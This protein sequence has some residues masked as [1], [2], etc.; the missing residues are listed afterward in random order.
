MNFN[1]IHLVIIKYFVNYT[2]SKKNTTQKLPPAVETSLYL[3]SER[4]NKE[5]ITAAVEELFRISFTCL[6][7]R[8]NLY[9]HSRREISSMYQIN[10]EYI[11]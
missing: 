5:M 4:F 6:Y 2:E 11:A 1:K 9:L 10:T 8:Q 7:P 3:F